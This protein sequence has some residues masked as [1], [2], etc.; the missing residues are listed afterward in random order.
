MTA[1]AL[2]SSPALQQREVLARP[3]QEKNGYDV[4]SEIAQ[5]SFKEL[6]VIVLF[7]GATLLFVA[8]L[9]G[10]VTLV[11]LAISVFAINTLLRMVAGYFHYSALCAL[12][13]GRVKKGESLNESSTF[14]K[15][16]PAYYFAH[17]DTCTRNV[18]VHE[19]G[20]AAAAYLFYLDPQP[21][22]TINPTYG[23]ATSFY[24]D[25][26]TPLGKLFG[27]KGSEIITTAAGSAA[28]VGF[29]L[30]TLAYAARLEDDEGLLKMYLILSSV[31]SIAQH[32]FYAIS[33]F[34][35]PST[36]VSH[37]FR[38]LW[39]YGIH[40][41]VSIIPMAISPFVAYFS[42]EPTKSEINS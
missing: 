34:W 16:L 5:N 12:K 10:A 4:I 23:G 26:L 13:E 21:R 14:F 20:H 35:T 25:Q 6:G 39:N 27:S 42:Q 38:A 31:S 18:I 7:S 8:T 32:I 37:D 19:M 29:S 17:F 11:T 3:L 15:F 24:A 33:A 30:A 28:A 41:L 2:N 22:I 40:P 1:I 36:M 9:Q